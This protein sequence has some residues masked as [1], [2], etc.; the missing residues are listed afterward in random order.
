MRKNINIKTIQ[1]DSETPIS[2]RKMAKIITQNGVYIGR[3]DLFDWLRERGLC[4]KRGGSNLP[5]DYAKSLGLMKA[6]PIIKND[7]KFPTTMITDKGQSYILQEFLKEK[8][9]E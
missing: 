1:N 3:N 5:T 4:E 2:V 9:A 8:I 7:I 6:E